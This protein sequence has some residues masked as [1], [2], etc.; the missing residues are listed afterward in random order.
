MEEAEG[1]DVR[2][3]HIRFFASVN[4]ATIGRLLAT[5]EQ[6]LNE[7]VRRFVI[8]LASPGGGV[9]AGISAYNFLKGIPAEVVT[10]NFGNIDSIATVLYCAGAKRYCVPHARFLLHGI[11]FDVQSARFDERL[12]DER[13]KDLRT[14]REIMGRIIAE[15]CKRPLEKVE[16]DILQGTVLNA[17]QAVDC[18]LVHE[19]RLQ[20]FEAGA[21]IIALQ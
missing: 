1:M 15:A 14:D 21:E 4:E 5:V 2:T 10:H 7:G 19:V 11:G 9:S 12:L 13:I 17:Q 20:L 16:Q 6:K 3:A 8:L 18:G